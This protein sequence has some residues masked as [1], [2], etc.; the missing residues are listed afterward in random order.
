[1]RYL[2]DT[3]T[4]IWFCEGSDKLSKAAKEI[5]YDSNSQLYVSMASLWEFTIKY[6]M[7]KLK[8]DGGLPKL[9]ELLKQADF[10]LLPITQV[11]LEC[12][13]DLQ[14]IHRDPFDRLLVATAKVD[15][16]TILTADENIY[17]YDVLTIW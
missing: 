6:S 17:R 5:T 10:I 11:Y 1:M 16:M 4:A 15:E 3:H 12:L 2:L 8:F 13:N 9:C 14:Y 7:G